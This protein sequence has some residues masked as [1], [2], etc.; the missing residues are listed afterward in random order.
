MAKSDDLRP[1]RTAPRNAPEDGEKRPSGGGGPPKLKLRLIQQ[2]KM[3][4]MFNIVPIVVVIWLAW[5][6]HLGH[7]R[8]NRPVGQHQLRDLA[9]VGVA[10]LVLALSGWVMLP[11][12]RWLRAY[13]AWQLRHSPSS[14]VWMLPTAA[15]WCA[16]ALIWL[17][18]IATSLVCIAV[19]VDTILDL[20]KGAGAG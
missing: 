14:W 5:E 10:C 3:L 9:L 2:L 7:V 11:F 4:A 13:P 20:A 19:L 16:W 1:A 12:G 6:Y 18:T 17:V 15:G 8:L